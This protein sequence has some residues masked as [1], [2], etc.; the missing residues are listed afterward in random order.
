MRIN[1]NVKVFFKGD[2][3]S[4]LFQQGFIC[5]TQLLSDQGFNLAFLKITFYLRF[6]N[7]DHNC[8]TTMVSGVWLSFKALA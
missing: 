7:F 2:S 4:F 6:S 1:E 3:Y 5:V 8:P